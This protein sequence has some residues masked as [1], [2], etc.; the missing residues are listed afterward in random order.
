MRLLSLFIFLF[1]LTLVH[2]QSCCERSSNNAFAMLGN[3]AEFVAGHG[4]N[5][6]EPVLLKSGTNIKFKVAGDKPANGYL[7]PANG[8]TNKFLFVFH[9]W[10]GL[11]AHIKKESEKLFE[12]LG[13]DVNVL[14]IDL[15]D[16]KT[17]VTA[18][19]AG[20]LMQNAKEERI[21]AI[22]DGAFAYAEADAE[23][24]TIGWCFGGGWSLQASMQGK[25][26]VEACVM[27]YGMPEKDPDRLAQIQAPVLGFFAE[28]DTWITHDLVDTFEDRMR[29]L[30]KDIEIHWYDAVHAFA[31]PSNKEYNEKFAAAAF[32]KSVAFI[33]KHL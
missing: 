7:I 27:Y 10:W 25:D 5:S 21:R 26:N 28:Q 19:K 31:N 11:N 30:E 8:K 2:G 17:A 23:V 29:A 13:E 24:A 4:Y 14:A 18:E 6:E 33:S 12:A 15:Y 16:G 32:V 20:Q 22:I 3:D 9:E 1:S